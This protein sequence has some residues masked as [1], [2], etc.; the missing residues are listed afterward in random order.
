MMVTTAK[1]NNASPHTGTRCRSGRNGVWLRPRRAWALVPLLVGL[2]LAV[3]PAGSAHAAIAQVQKATAASAGNASSITA[4]YG[5]APTQDNLLVL[6]HHYMTTGTVT[7]PA[8]WTQAVLQQGSAKFTIA[9]KIAGAAEGT[10]VTVSV[11]SSDL[12]TITIFEYSGIDTLDQTASNPCSTLGTSCSTGTTATTVQADELVIA[13]IATIGASGGW[14][15]AA[16]TTCLMPILAHGMRT[17]LVRSR[18]PLISGCR[19]R[20]V[21]SP[22]NRRIPCS[23]HRPGR[24]EQLR[25]PTVVARSLIRLDSSSLNDRFTFEQRLR[26]RGRS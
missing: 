9:Y 4:T 24:R 6:V 21:G 7:L 8:G 26:E 17:F 12:Q 16:S 25:W 3:F 18:T 11:S 2:G 22:P 5:A 15:A 14:G 1:V 10:G 13:G 23:S 19:G 20:T